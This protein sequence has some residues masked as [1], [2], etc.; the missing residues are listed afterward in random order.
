[1]GLAPEYEAIVNRRINRG[2]DDSDISDIETLFVENGLAEALTGDGLGRHLADVLPGE[3]PP[4]EFRHGKRH[5]SDDSQQ[6]RR[7]P[8]HRRIKGVFASVTLV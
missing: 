8:R 3:F 5:Q 6:E 1:M 2:P 7:P 4:D